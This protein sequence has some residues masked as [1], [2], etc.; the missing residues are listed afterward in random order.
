M[1]YYDEIIKLCKQRE[2]TIDELMMKIGKS[3]A[4]YYGWRA[5][6]IS[7]RASDLYEIC[8]VLNVSMEHF[9]EDE[10][11]YTVPPKIKP[12]VKNFE[13]LSADDLE[14]LLS[15]S[16]AQLQNLIKLFKSIKN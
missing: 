12:L 10:E 13:Q 7:P 14:V 4:T 15:L 3:S 16:P 1:N 6:N 8:K 2:I 11:S 5:R 9:F